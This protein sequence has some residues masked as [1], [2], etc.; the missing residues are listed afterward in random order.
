MRL[1][2]K[3]AFAVAGIVA[4]TLS[5]CGAKEDAPATASAKP[6]AKPPA[7]FPSTYKAYPGTATAIRNVTIYDGEGGKIDNGV[8]FMSGGKISSVG[9]PETPIPADIAVF[10]GAGKFVT[11]GIIDIHSHLGDYPSPSVE[12]HSDGNEATSP[13]TPEVWAEHSVWPQDPG[14]QPRAGQWRGDGVAGIA[15]FGEPDGRAFCRA[16]KRLCANGAGHEISRRALW[17]ED[18]VRRKSKARLR[19]KGADAIDAN[20]QCCGQSPDMDQGARV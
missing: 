6:A 15:G 18:G 20:G 12:A 10:D 5:G 2:G 4:L 1:T 13:T 19:R 16:E 3:A 11:P 8:L 17:Y 14:F 9:G 7:P